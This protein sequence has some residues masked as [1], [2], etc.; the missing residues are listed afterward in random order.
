MNTPTKKPSRI[1]NII[2]KVLMLIVCT[3]FFSI[4]FTIIS[5]LKGHT[6]YY[7]RYPVLIIYLYIVLFKIM[8]FKK[9]QKK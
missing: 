4:A 5:E 6:A 7:S 1:V 2:K 9:K 3:F 8:G